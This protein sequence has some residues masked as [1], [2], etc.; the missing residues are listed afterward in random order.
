MP[1]NTRAR[2]VLGVITALACVVIVASYGAPIPSAPFAPVE[3]S[4]PS[5]VSSD[6]STTAVVIDQARRVALVN[7][8]SQLTALINLD[9]FEAPIEVATD[10]CVSGERVYVAGLKRA[11]DG[12]QIER[13]RIV[14]YDLSGR[15]REIVH[16]IEGKGVRAQICALDDTE[17]GVLFALRGSAD[18]EAASVLRFFSIDAGKVKE[19]SSVE[20]G[21]DLIVEASY[22][23][24][25]DT[26]ATLSYRGILN[27]THDGN[28]Q[29]DRLFTSISVSNDGSIYACENISGLLVCIGP[30]GSVSAIESDVPYDC[31]RVQG[32]ILCVVGRDDDVV[33]LTDTD[34][35]PLAEYASVVPT[36]WASMQVVALWVSVAFL[37]LLLLALAIRSIVRLV[38]G[39]HAQELA[40]PFASL[41]VVVTVAV[42]LGSTAFQSFSAQRT[43][44]E[45]EI[46]A[47]ADYLEE[48]SDR[49][50]GDL[51]PAESRTY[52]L[53]TD[54]RNDTREDESLMLALQQLLSLAE[55]ASSNNVGLY[56]SVFGHD[57]TEAFCLMDSLGEYVW[58]QS[59]AGASDEGDVQRAFAQ[60]SSS[61]KP[62][63]GNDSPETRLYRTVYV[64]PAGEGQGFV[65]E[66]GSRI[67]SFSATIASNLVRNALALL[68]LALVIY[69]G[70]A[71]LRASGRCV[72]RYRRMQ[73]NGEA[74]AI[75]ALARPFALT[76]MMLASVDGVMSTLIAKDLLGA[77]GYAEGTPLVAVPAVMLGIG[78]AIGQGAYGVIGSRVG[79]RRL[80]VR[81]SI[82]MIA[83]ALCAVGTVIAENFWAYC[84][85]KLLLSIP[86]GL[87]YTAAYSLR[88]HAV[89]KEQ[90][91]LAKA[92]VK[93]SNTSS[94]ALGT[95]LGGYAAQLLGN[96]GV[97]L[98]LGLVGL[99]LALLA[100]WLIP[101]AMLPPED[102]RDF[103]R[104]ERARIR[105]FALSPAAL[106]I[107][108]CIILPSVVATG[109]ASFLFPLFSSEMG[110]AKADISN[111]YLFGQ[112][113]VYV[114]ISGI[115]VFSKRVG[116]WGTAFYA[117]GG[118][119][120]VFAAFSLNTTVVWGVV[121]IALVGL[122]VKAAAVWKPLWIASAEEANVPLGWATGAMFIVRSVARIAKPFILGALIVS[123]QPSVVVIGAFCLAC[124]AVLS[125]RLRR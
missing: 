6:G 119:G 98:A 52:L 105:R 122:L 8:K 51:A 66:V 86:F 109:Y 49:L 112:L 38:R 57:G 75:S 54:A 90:Q 73:A 35:N 70:Y 45:N 121:V 79:L 53:Q 10:V 46:N 110:F 19:L 7:N 111:M 11:R 5:A 64:P 84:V 55:T 104:E 59:I 60:R 22:A 62:C 13:E 4:K 34:G 29:D 61:T 58:G 31:V 1:K 50:K 39:G 103:S 89:S 18:D 102:D 28:K 74:G 44:R 78:Q 41:A 120:L 23:P 100:L 116:N 25:A 2:I 17:S 72:V 9:T 37:A 82:V 76:T 115:E 69:M 15:Q 118:L 124:A 40:G 16:E 113:V 87:L 67:D 95:A 32:E 114:S 93:R 30:D 81:W 47:Y 14:A 36:V 24:P 20:T 96:V 21:V 68:V 101:V 125:F 48:L 71:E 85:A 80:M 123:G 26:L 97:Y 77:A 3:L 92:G 88:R 117:I 83:C 43:V 99:A 65:I 106:V 56:V 94:A 33:R 107:A 42:A 27:D 12:D 63:T 108:F 91:N